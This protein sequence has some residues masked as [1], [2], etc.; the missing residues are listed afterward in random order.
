M[1]LRYRLGTA[2]QA[3]IHYVNLHSLQL[4]RDITSDTSITVFENGFKQMD[5]QCII[6]TFLKEHVLKQI[7]LISTFLNVIK[8]LKL[9]Y[10]TFF[11]FKCAFQLHQ[12]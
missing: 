2:I 12:Q 11:I 5:L 9:K 10:P 3:L 1:I 6:A 4:P 7:A 8:Q